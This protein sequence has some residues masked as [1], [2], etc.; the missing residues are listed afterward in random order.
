MTLISRYVLRLLLTYAAGI[1]IAALAALLLERMLRLLDLSVN[2]DRVAG[3]VSGMLLNLLPHYLGI[4]LPA[5][6]F[7][8]TLLTVSR[9]SRNSELAVL[10]SAGLS[11]MG[12]MRP[13]LAVALLLAG[14]VAA[15]TSVVQP[16]SR[17]T[18]RALVHEVSYRSLD[19]A[20]K[21]GSFIDAEGM[22]VMAEGRALRSNQLNNIFVYSQADDGAAVVTTAPAGRLLRQTDR[23]STQLALVRG[24]RTEIGPQGTIDRRLGFET[25]LWSIDAEGFEPFR[26]RGKDERELTLGELWQS[27]SAPPP[28]I[29][30]AAIVAEF[31]SRLV[32]IVSMLVLPFLALPLGLSGS[33]SGQFSGVAIGVFVLVVYDKALELGGAMSGLDIVSPWLGLWLPFAVFVA[34]AGSLFLLVSRRAATN[35][36]AWLASQVEAASAPIVGAVGRLIQRRKTA[37]V[38]SRRRT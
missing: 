38:R 2:S 8:A 13:V 24:Y 19:A 9:L 20:L 31:H 21:Q 7:L 23:T 16:Y 15:M 30:G 14:V 34:A 6:F 32:K 4:A 22:T 37:L 33:R 36:V 5:T 27:R 26:N 1:M 35:P 12:L 18:Y 3:Y 29:S 11:F 10:S 25:F 17:Y 28:L